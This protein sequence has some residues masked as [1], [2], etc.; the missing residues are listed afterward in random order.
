[1]SEGRVIVVGGG[2]AG[3]SAAVAC[4][5]AG[6]RVTL[7]EARSRLGGATWS[8]AR[9]GLWID[10]G[11]HVFLR[12]CTAY[13]AFLRRLGVA[14][15]T[16]L[17]RRLAVPIADATGRL[18]W[19]RRAP[20]P[21]PLH[22]APSLLRYRHLP[23]AERLRAAHLTRAL[24]RLDLRDPALRLERFGTWLTERGASAA[25]LD[26]FWDLLIRPTLNVAA[27]DAS[28]A[29]AAKVFQ[30]GLLEG[31]DHADVG[32]AV[33]PLQALHADPAKATLVA[34]GAV[35]HERAPVDRID[36]VGDKE[37]A[38]WVAGERY[39]ARA[40]VVAADHEAAAR[41]LP[42]AS[43]VDRVAVAGLG[44]A[45]IVNLHVF[46]DRPVMHHPFLATVG[47]P[48]QW[49]FDR[50]ESSGFRY[51]Q[52]LAISL[53]AAQPYLGL[54]RSELRRRFVPELERVFPRARSARLVRFFS[55]CERAATFD[56]S[57]GPALGRLGT[58]TGHPA[59]FV[60]GAWT[61]TGWPATMEGAV[62]SGA[63]AAAAALT[64]LGVASPHVSI[65]TASGGD[66]RW[67]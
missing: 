63:A 46:Y 40:V 50:T 29:L 23:F 35:V 9:D 26:R 49:V 6:V 5:D 28:L 52:Y 25:S 30:T 65:G 31:A 64:E 51:G 45:P 7:F 8:F 3:L 59:L 13:R 15:K 66:P 14:E 19:L 27:A 34:A 55:T 18:A 17:Q 10:N 4:A 21:A 62:R 39:P 67:N 24:G 48:L 41:L 33:V 37:A 44:R 56:Q 36:T 11:Q 61:D 16:H 58:R 53:S 54:P 57:A 38:V 12:C 22:L 20:L 42:E 1:V 2:L 32:Y 60:A 47:S 43:G